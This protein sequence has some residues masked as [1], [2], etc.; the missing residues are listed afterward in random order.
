M[1]NNFTIFPA[2][3][4]RAGKVVRLAQGDPERQ[5][6]Y[7]D[8]PRLWAER[9]KAEGAEW[10]HVIN[11]SGAFDE[12][13]HLN[14]KAL[15]SILT[16]GLHVEFGGGIR[17]EETVRVPLEM[18]VERVFLG[19]AAVQDPALVDW[20]IATYGPARIAGDIGARDGKVTVKGWQETTAQSVLEI[21]QRLHSQGIEW[22]VLTDVSRDGVS[23]GV[24]V[25]GAVELQNATGLNVVASGGASSL[26]D[27]RRARKAGLAGVIIGRSLYD[28]KISL[29]NVVTALAV[30]SD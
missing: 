24:N 17:N 11:L 26:E 2:I 21:G 19:T 23:N 29:K 25:A 13:I 9:W 16:V 15:E 27:V 10:L 5:T 4:L 7:G 18:G 12:D 22:C 3:D 6:S 8:D 14:M 28:G 30:Q 20:A 1:V